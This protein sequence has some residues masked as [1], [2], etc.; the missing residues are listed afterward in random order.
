MIDY[1]RARR[2]MVDTQVRVNDVTDSRIVDAL[3]VV[4]RETFVPEQRR[5]LA[6]LDDDLPLNVPAPGVAARFLMEPM[7]FAR[8]LQAAAIGEGDRVLDVGSATGYSAAVLARLAGSVVA[9]EA[10]EVLSAEARRNLAGLAGVTLADGPLAD[11]AEAHGPFDV[12]LVEGAA[13]QV[14]QS[15]LSQLADGGR[16]VAVVGTGR[17]AKCLVHEKRGGEISVRA[18]FDAAIPS[19]PGFEAPRGFVF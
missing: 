4:P 15:L 13:E 5:A 1:A 11:G 3:M 10:D 18:A 2:T 16:L 19:L 9:L 6:Y 14:P 7:V 12:I 8:M 17:A